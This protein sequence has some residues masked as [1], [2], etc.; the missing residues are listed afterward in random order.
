MGQFIGIDASGISVIICCYN[1]EKTI[2]RVLDG[3]K[4]Q[5]NILFDYE[6]LVVNNKS[7]DNTANLVTNYITKNNNINIKLLSE[8]RPGLMFAREKGIKESVYDFIQFCDDDN[9]LSQNY[10]SSVYE[11]FKSNH[12]IGAC[13]GLGIELT[14][15]VIPPFWFE[16]YKKSYAVGSQVRVI[17]D[18]LYG[19][20]VAIRKKALNLV[21][22][23][24]FRS[25]LSGRK[26]N[27]LLAGDDGELILAMLLCGYKLRAS[28]SFF[29]MHIINSSRLTKAYLL[30]L[31]EGF[32]KMYPVI[33]IYREV[34]KSNKI[35]S[36]IYYESK[37]LLKVL[38]SFISIF[39]KLGIDQKVQIRLFIGLIKGYFLFNRDLNQIIKIIKQLKS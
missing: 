24:G 7:T 20:G 11:I 39:F 8:N 37:F 23:K 33:D 31:H 15:N 27:S 18:H 25:F 35:K 32:G 14:D 19:A 34:L 26:G 30:D 1:S 29:F 9:I 22:T 13:G 16:K 36:K 4:N 3:I 12:E 10:L 21:Y 28:D 6:V 17:Q 38:K 5:K 2:L